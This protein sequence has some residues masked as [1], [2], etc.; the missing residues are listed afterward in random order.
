MFPLLQPRDTQ[1]SK[2]SSKG[3]CRNNEYKKKQTK[4]TTMDLLDAIKSGDLEKV[5]GVLEGD[6][7]VDPNGPR[8]KEFTHGMCLPLAIEVGSM[9]VAVYLSTRVSP[10]HVTEALPF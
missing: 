1:K 8:T 2:S 6:V 9:D 10:Q 3:C 7:T 5:R 4:N